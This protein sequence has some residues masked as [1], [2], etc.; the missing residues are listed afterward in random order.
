MNNKMTVQEI[1]EKEGVGGPFYNHLDPGI[2]LMILDQLAVLG[3]PDEIISRLHCTNN[4]VD[5]YRGYCIAKYEDGHS[6]RTRSDQIFQL[7]IYLLLTLIQVGEFTSRSSEMLSY[8]V[9]AINM[10]IPFVEGGEWSALE[11]PV[12]K[13]VNL[14]FLG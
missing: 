11:V 6:F 4:A 8:L 1:L 2:T 5:R 3:I 12:R 10:E 14:S 7:R 13:N 9:S